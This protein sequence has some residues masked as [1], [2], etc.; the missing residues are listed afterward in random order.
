MK[1]LDDNFPG[2]KQ[3]AALA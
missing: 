3:H 2:V 1:I